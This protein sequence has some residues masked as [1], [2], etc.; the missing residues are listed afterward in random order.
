MQTVINDADVFSKIGDNLF[1]GFAPPTVTRPYIIYQQI[2]GP[3]DQTFDGPSGLTTI[4]V[5][6]SIF[7]STYLG[8]RT[9]ADYLRRC[10]DG[11]EGTVSLTGGGSCKILETK[12]TDEGDIPSERPDNVVVYG[13]RQD[14]EIVIDER[15]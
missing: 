10:L 14:Y 6:M 15:P 7:D 13:K 3:R 1:N 12:L 2:S 5:Q 11:F 8:A 9:T 4:H